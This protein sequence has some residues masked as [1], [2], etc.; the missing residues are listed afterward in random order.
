MTYDNEQAIATKHKI[1]SFTDLDAWRAAHELYV[2]IYKI[3]KF[4]P[5]EEQFGITDQIRRAA[6][7]VSSNIAEGFGRSPRSADRI[8]FYTIGRGSLT[9]VQNQLLAARDVGLLKVDSFSMLSNQSI[10]AH[11]LLV[12]LIKAT[13]RKD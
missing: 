11:K 2:M 12:G 6:L 10:K 5:R 8:H 1:K 4:F 7:S 13:M 9:E 3:T